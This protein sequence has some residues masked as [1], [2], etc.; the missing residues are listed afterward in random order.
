VSEIVATL[1]ERFSGAPVADEVPRFLAALR[2][3]GWLR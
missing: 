3:E 2:K 1:A